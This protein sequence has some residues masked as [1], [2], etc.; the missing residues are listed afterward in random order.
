MFLDDLFEIGRGK[1]KNTSFSPTIS[2]C[3]IDLAALSWSI[4]MAG[5]RHQK[6]FWI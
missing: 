3:H 6:L 2:C 4:C 5:S 1:A